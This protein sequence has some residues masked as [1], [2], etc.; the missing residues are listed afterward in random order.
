MYNPNEHDDDAFMQ[1]SNNLQAQLSEG[2]DDLWSAGAK[3]SDIES[4]LA[5]AVEN[6]EFGSGSSVTVSITGLE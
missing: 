5:T 4:E 3:V 6:T 1:A 2:L